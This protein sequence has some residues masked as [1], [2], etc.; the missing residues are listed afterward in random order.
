MKKGLKEDELRRIERTLIR[1][2]VKHNPA[3][4]AGILRNRKREMVQNYAEYAL[5]AYR[6]TRVVKR[7]ADSLGVPAIERFWYQNFARQV[8]KIWRRRHYLNLKEELKVNRL[9]WGLRGLNP[10]IL[11]LIEG[12]VLAELQ[13]QEDPEQSR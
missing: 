2:E 8:E 7:V 4:I 11:E 3:Q 13:D 9:K 1:Y 6:L 5:I 12:A 10:F